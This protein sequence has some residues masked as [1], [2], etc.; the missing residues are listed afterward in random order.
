MPALNCLY[1]SPIGSGARAPWLADNAPGSTRDGA[2]K[3][4]PAPPSAGRPAGCHRTA[5]KRSRPPPRRSLLHP[6][7]AVGGDYVGTASESQHTQS[8]NR[9]R[10]TGT[11]P[12]F[13]YDQLVA[14]TEYGVQDG[15]AISRQPLSQPMTECHSETAA[16]LGQNAEGSSWVSGG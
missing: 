9:T 10:N 13:A 1:R 11:H 12:P 14:S 4:P 7:H 6:M 15:G 8:Q 5:Q 2:K 3:A 16:F